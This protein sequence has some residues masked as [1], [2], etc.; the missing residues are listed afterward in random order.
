MYV[1]L[2]RIISA[3]LPEIHTIEKYYP[4]H[5]SFL[6]QCNSLFYFNYLGVLIYRIFAIQSVLAGGILH[7]VNKV[8]LQMPF[9][10]NI[11]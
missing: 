10:I 11:Q 6:K 8:P 9:I 7:T 1:M 2:P 5:I 3:M 4:E